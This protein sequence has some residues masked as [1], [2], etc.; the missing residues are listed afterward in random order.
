MS[1][2]LFMFEGKLRPMRE[3]CAMVPRITDSSLRK[4]IAAGRNTVMSILTYDHKGASAN[5]ARK[6]H[7]A[8]GKP[9]LLAQWKEGERR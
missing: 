4:H 7:A 3:I 5:G 2:K 9:S 8:K 1:V 6:A